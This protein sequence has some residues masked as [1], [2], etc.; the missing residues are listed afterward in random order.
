MLKGRLINNQ[1]NFKTKTSK[2]YFSDKTINY[3]E[4]NIAITR[5]QEKCGKI[6]SDIVKKYKNNFTKITI[7]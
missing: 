1:Y 6:L 4:N 7:I 3:N 5:K 2:H